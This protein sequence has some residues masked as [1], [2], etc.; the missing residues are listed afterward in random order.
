MKKTQNEQITAEFHNYNGVCNG[1]YIERTPSGKKLKITTC[2]DDGC[3]PT[4][5]ITEA[6]IWDGSSW[7]FICKVKNAEYN[8]TSAIGSHYNC[9]ARKLTESD[10]AGVVEHVRRIAM[11]IIED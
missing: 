11:A 2:N 10:F 6:K 9:N 5:A 7:S 4:R 3:S 1:L 8:A